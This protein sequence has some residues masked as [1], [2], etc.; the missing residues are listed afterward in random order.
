MDNERWKRVA[1]NET[2]REEKGGFVLA[3]QSLVK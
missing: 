1:A 2:G 3:R